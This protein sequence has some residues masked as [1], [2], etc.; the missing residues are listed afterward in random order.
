MRKA[1]LW[2]DI[3]HPINIGGHGDP[4]S[5]VGETIEN[6]TFRDI[7]ILEQDEDDYPYQGCMAVVCGDKNLARNILFEDIRIESIQEGMMFNIRVNY[8]PK[9]DKQPGR[10]ID[11]LTFRNITYDGIGED[12][13]VIFGFDE[14]R[15]VKNVTFENIVIN[16]KKMKDTKDFVK[17]EFVDNIV[18]K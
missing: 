17:N 18:V 13:S 4:E 8:N 11:G 6:L 9:Y 15:R 1:V 3:A 5:E 2:A 16:G 14:S 7:D 12:K 10:G